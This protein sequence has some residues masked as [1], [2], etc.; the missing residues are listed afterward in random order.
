MDKAKDPLT[1]EIFQKQRNNQRFAS[2]KNQI[3]HNNLRAREKAKAKALV[4]SYLDKNR[5][6]LQKALGSKPSTTN[7]KDYLLGAGFFFGCHTHNIRKEGA[8]WACIYDYAYRRDG[9]GFYK[10]IKHA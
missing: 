6:I 5:A 8:I 4:D 3:R 2:R 9:D 10:I 7:S 1:G